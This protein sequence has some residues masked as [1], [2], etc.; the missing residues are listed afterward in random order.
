ME[1]ESEVSHR[2]TAGVKQARRSERVKQ[3]VTDLI[4]NRIPSWHGLARPCPSEISRE[5]EMRGS[6]GTHLPWVWL[7]DSQACKDMHSHSR[8][9]CL[10]GPRMKT[11]YQVS[12]V[13]S[14]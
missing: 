9:E 11:R 3:Y 1:F 8:E 4:G 2:H 6:D 10:W 13:S 14:D 12:A 7:D 5:A